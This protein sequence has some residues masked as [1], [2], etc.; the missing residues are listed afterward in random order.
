MEREEYEKLMEYLDTRF[1]NIERLQTLSLVNNV[2]EDYEKVVRE[3]D[4]ESN[5]IALT[6]LCEQLGVALVSIET[7]G[8][9]EA[10]YIKKEKG[11]S[12]TEIRE[13]SNIIKKQGKYIPVF[14]MDRVHGNTRKKLLGER[15][16]YVV[17]GKEKYIYG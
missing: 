14:I 13:I 10:C 17:E 16:S 6:E 2:L 4:K 15:I 1:E 12:L 8:D 5:R 3:V 11:I 7:F 9:K